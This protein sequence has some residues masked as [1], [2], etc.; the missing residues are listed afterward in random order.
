MDEIRRQIYT[1]ITDYIER[2][3][4]QFRSCNVIGTDL[5]ELNL[6]YPE[7]Q[8]IM[9]MQIPVKEKSKHQKK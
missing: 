6:F 7:G 4:L 3:G 1:N 5:H 8:I 9:N 2:N